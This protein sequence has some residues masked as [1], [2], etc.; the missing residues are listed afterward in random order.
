MVSVVEAH[1]LPGGGDDWVVFVVRGHSVV[2]MSID[3][4]SLE[5]DV[6]KTI[7]TKGDLDSV[8]DAIRGELSPVDVDTAHVGKHALVLLSQPIRDSKFTMTVDEMEA[9]TI[10]ASLIGGLFG[11]D[12][13]LFNVDD[14][15]AM[16]TWE[17]YGNSLSPMEQLKWA[18]KSRLSLFT[19]HHDHVG[20]SLVD[21]GRV[22]DGLHYDSANWPWAWLTADRLASDGDARYFAWNLDRARDVILDNDGSDE[23]YWAASPNDLE[24]DP[25]TLRR[26]QVVER[27][28]LESAA[29]GAVML[30]LKKAYGW[31]AWFLAEAD[32]RERESDKLM[33]ISLNEGLDAIMNDSLS[34]VD[35]REPD[36]SDDDEAPIVTVVED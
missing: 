19:T 14:A 36:A 10:T 13:E 4:D 15:V 18:R 12:V 22:I 16:S 9:T 32:A 6:S 3:I 5:S 11:S 29:R 35:D 17:D 30:A 21:S 2:V 34:E 23:V 24:F 7:D 8:L 25:T 33:E 26:C 31:R 1:E 20:R 27:S 28:W